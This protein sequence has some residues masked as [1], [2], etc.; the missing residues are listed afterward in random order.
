[1]SLHLKYRPDDLSQFNIHA[2]IA[3]NFKQLVSQGDMPHCLLY[4][5]SGAG[6]KTLIRAML[7]EIYGEQVFKTKVES[8]PWVIELPNRKIEVEMTCVNSNY[9]VE[10]IPSDAGF[11]D[12]YVV[13]EIVKQMA[14]NRSVDVSKFKV[15]YIKCADQMSQSAQHSLRRTMEKY[16][17]NARF[18]LSCNNLANITDPL[19]S[20]CLCIRVPLPEQMQVEQ[21][22][23][24]VIGKEGYN[25]PSQFLQNLIVQTGCNLR[26]TLLALEATLAINSGN[27]SDNTQIIQLP[28]EQE[29]KSIAQMVIDKQSPSQIME[30]REKLYSLL[31]KTIPGTII[32]ERLMQN[33]LEMRL[34]DCVRIEIVKLA[35]QYSHDLVL[36]N[37]AIFVLEAY[38][39]SVMKS[40]Q[41][42]LSSM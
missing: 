18:V 29:I 20:R 33:F 40:Y 11:Q 15:I 3:N 30:V 2:D 28:W 36:A 8:K 39:V 34:D 24:E 6:K 27:I 1:M 31:V 5:P 32:L 38:V 16:S 14:T 23:K 12:R 7:K 9:H 19:Q 22:M 10:F 42:F 25:I 37:K 4:G 26:K 35:A 21:F 13:Q 17:A 41:T